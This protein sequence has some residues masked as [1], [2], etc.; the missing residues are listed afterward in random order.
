MNKI[1]LFF[2]ILFALAPLEGF[3]QL[4]NDGSYIWNTIQVNHQFNSKY[5]LVF[6]NR[7]FYS[8]ISDRLDFYFLD[9][10]GYRALNK[11]ISMG[12]GYRRTESYKPDQWNPGNIFWTYGVIYAKTAGIKL[13]IATRLGYKTFKDIDS[14][15]ALDNISTVDFF[16]N[17]TSKFP[18]PYLIEEVFSE[19]K[20]LKVQNM[21]LFTGLHLLKGQHFGF[22]V[23]YAFWKSNTSSGWKDYNVYGIATKI[24]L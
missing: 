19:L 20:S 21:K 11:H 24:N 17:S 2:L 13:K 12:L 15:I 22:D 14:Q 3:C 8:D 18:K 1:I 23:F 10:T 4:G 5:E 16:T 7:I 6:T 9:L